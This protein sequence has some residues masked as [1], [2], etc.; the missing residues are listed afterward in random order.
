MI[1]KNSTVEV[2]GNM[3]G[4]VI[5]M[6]VDPNG[7]LKLMTMMTDIY[8]DAQLACIREYSCNAWDAHV[9]AGV[10]RP[11]EVRLPQGFQTNLE[12]Q[13]FGVGMDEDTIRNV[14]SS[15]LTST[16]DTTNDAT[17]M[18]GIGCKA[19]LSYTDQF[20]VTSIKDGHRIQVVVSRVATGG[21]TM[22]IVD[23]RSTDEGNGTTVSIPVGAYNQFAEKAAEFFSYWPAGTVLVD[24]KEPKRFEGLK[25]SDNLYAVKNPGGSWSREHT[26][27][28]GNVP[29][30]LPPERIQ[31]GLP[32]GA[33]LVAYVPI[34]S[35]QVPAPREGLL[36]DD[37]ET[38]KGLKKIEGDFRR[39]ARAAVQ[40]EINSAP[41]HHSAIRIAG[42]WHW[43]LNR[44]APFH[45]TYRGSVISEKL[46][47]TFTVAESHPG[48]L[49]RATE[50][51]HGLMMRNVPDTIFVTGWNY[52]KWSAAQR[53]KL[54]AYLAEK[55]LSASYYA[56]CDTVAPSPFVKASQIIKW[57]DVKKI[58]LAQ[59][60]TQSGRIPGSYDLMTHAD[61]YMREGVA[62]DDIDTESPVFFC[63]D[64]WQTS[65]YVQALKNFHDEFTVVYLPSTRQAKFKRMCPRVRDVKV[66][67]QSMADKYAATLSADERKAWTLESES[68][69]KF[70]LRLLNLAQAAGMKI[71]DPRVSERGRLA[72]IDLTN[73][74][75]QARLFRN[76]LY[77]WHI[78]GL[79]IGDDPIE[80]YPLIDWSKITE[81]TIDYM[82]WHYTT[83]IKED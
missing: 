14:Y 15:Y 34:G 16:K 56:M 2:N 62:G 31:T 26:V 82:N 80:D 20:I 38:I 40:R 21:G 78:P 7:M 49:G 39:E 12:I 74:R 25:V 60:R 69:P 47:G 1:H 41:D 64:K 58:K 67:I 19:A 63:S 59:T 46:A 18:F 61:A 8:D 53:R 48:K 65:T 10:T 5:E 29:Y 30:P 22:R 71:E 4:E 54:D 75:K 11:I 50:Q 55:G 35:V 70:Y 17:G 81:H 23:A 43:T 32:Y 24:G 13:D 33:S 57:E 83:T 9:E 3:T 36:L 66:E 44:H 77:G 6:S 52:T 27:V 68:A 73:I 42:E 51:P 45:Y 37:Q 72:K 76:L 28:M 79:P